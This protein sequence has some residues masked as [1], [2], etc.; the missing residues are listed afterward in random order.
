MKVWYFLVELES[1][2]TIHRADA[3]ELPSWAVCPICGKEVII[4]DIEG[5]VLGIVVTAL[6]K[7]I[8]SSANLSKLGL[9]SLS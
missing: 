8:L 2:K 6:L 3:I 5:V 7:K 1:M 4:D 9:V